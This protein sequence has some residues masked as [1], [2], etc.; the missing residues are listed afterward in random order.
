MRSSSLFVAS[1]IID[2]HAAFDVAQFQHRNHVRSSKAKARLSINVNARLSLLS[3]SHSEG[4]H[5]GRSHFSPN[6]SLSH[7]AY[8]TISTS[9]MSTP[10]SVWAQAFRRSSKSKMSTPGF[11]EHK[12]NSGRRSQ[13]CQ[14]QALSGTSVTAVVEVKNVN[15]RLCRARA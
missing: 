4:F 11:L 5:T 14:H 13:K 1:I 10:C 2:E 8:S 3:C 7:I 15:T 12:R 9:R 6:V